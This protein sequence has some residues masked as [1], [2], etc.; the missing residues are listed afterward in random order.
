MFGRRRRQRA[1][2]Q[3]RLDGMRK[4]R[5]DALRL[6]GQRPGDDDTEPVDLEPDEREAYW[7]GRRSLRGGA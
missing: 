3:G 6:L 4:H 2:E 7:D 1:F 5:D